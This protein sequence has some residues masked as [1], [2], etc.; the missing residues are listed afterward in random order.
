MSDNK[1][2]S[3]F[4]TS[5]SK[6]QGLVKIKEHDGDSIKSTIIHKALVQ[7]YD[8]KNE[9]YPTWL[10]EENKS[11]TQEIQQHHRNVNNFERLHI[12]QNQ[13]KS[14]PVAEVQANQPRPRRANPGLN[15]FKDI[16]GSSRETEGTTTQTNVS[17]SSANSR[18][19]E[20]LRRNNYKNN[21]TG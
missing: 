1:F 11:R 6:I 16:Y 21:F 14:T 19:K 18:M 12:D 20:K 10:G 2:W 17:S 7:F 3:K 4:K 8:S 13:Q 9:D 15:S 5:T